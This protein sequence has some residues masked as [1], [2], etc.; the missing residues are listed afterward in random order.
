MI[1]IADERVREYIRRLRMASVLFDVVSFG[2]LIF[3]SSCQGLDIPE[4]DS[5][6]SKCGSPGL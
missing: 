5:F 1:L 4:P 2:N 3:R 6:S